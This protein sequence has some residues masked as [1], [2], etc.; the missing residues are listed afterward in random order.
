MLSAVTGA[1]RRTPMFLGVADPVLPEEPESP[2]GQ[3]AEIPLLSTVCRE[4]Y[5]P[6]PGTRREVREIAKLFQ[7]KP[8]NEDCERVRL[9]LGEDASD[10]KLSELAL[11][12]ELNRFEYIHFATHAEVDDLHHLGA[13]LVLGADFGEDAGGGWGFS[14]GRLTASEILR[15]WT[16]D[17][18]LVT[19]SACRTALGQRAGGDGYVGFTQVLLATGA[20]SVLLSLWDVPDDATTL[21]MHRFYRNLIRDGTSKAEALWE[22]KVWLRKLS[23]TERDNTL[24]ALSETRGTNREP[25]RG[26]RIVPAEPSRGP[27]PYA[28]PYYWAGFILLGSSSWNAPIPPAH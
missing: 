4:H 3:S 10:R 20:R 28:H 16:L 9:I 24:A 22:A 2:P 6:L 15:T 5:G 11:S 1:G 13:S 18:E 21:L 27:H 25:T 23:R 8:G 12:G 26:L 7:K 19:F 14:D 17:A